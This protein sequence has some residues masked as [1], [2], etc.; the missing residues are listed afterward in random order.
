MVNFYFSSFIQ[1]QPFLQ[2]YDQATVW[3]YYAVIVQVQLQ[4]WE[5]SHIEATLLRSA[6]PFISRHHTFHLKSI[7]CYHLQSTILL[8]LGVSSN[9][10]E[11]I[12]G[13]LDPGILLEENGLL[14]GSQTRDLLLEVQLGENTL[15]EQS[16]GLSAAT[17]LVVVLL[18]TL[19][20]ESE[21]V[22]T[23]LVD[24]LND[25]DGTSGD[26]SALLETVDG[27]RALGLFSA[28]HEVIVVGLALGANEVGC[29]QKRSGGSSN[30][31]NVGH[32]VGHV[33]FVLKWDPVGGSFSG[34]A[35]VSNYGI[36]KIGVKT[37]G[38]KGPHS[39]K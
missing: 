3:T 17:E 31:D 18:Q 4:Q 30:L 22:K 16:L 21:L 7:S 23:A 6:T 27:A 9:R 12:N 38:V 10:L 25:G 37:E 19:P 1:T 20:V 29:R 32:V 28:Q 34:P 5:R 36:D 13:R 24:V 15:V 39:N 2:W 26:S 35:L 14:V 33:S 11:V 8:S